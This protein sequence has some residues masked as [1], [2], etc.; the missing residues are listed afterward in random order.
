MLPRTPFY[1]LTGVQGFV[2][3]LVCDI[4]AI[5]VAEVTSDEVNSATVG[6]A[7]PREEQR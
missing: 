1:M 3:D 2:N 7:A 6:N 5:E 4:W